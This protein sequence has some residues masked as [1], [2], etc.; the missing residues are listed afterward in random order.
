MKSKKLPNPESPPEKDL[1]IL[2]EYKDKSFV[3]LFYEEKSGVVVH[4][5]DPQYHV[6]YYAMDWINYKDSDW[7]PFDGEITLSN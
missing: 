4:C 5:E 7:H 2:M 3:V 1:P 6:G